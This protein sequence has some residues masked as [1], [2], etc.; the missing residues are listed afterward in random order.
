VP[1][2]ERPADFLSLLAVFP[3]VASPGFSIRWALSVDDRSGFLIL[4]VQLARRT[5]A[6]LLFG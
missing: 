1:N 2:G 4:Y 6:C 3:V 5:V